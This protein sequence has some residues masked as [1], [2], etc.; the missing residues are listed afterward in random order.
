MKIFYNQCRQKATNAEYPFHRVIMNEN[1]FRDAV[2]YDHVCVQYKDNRRR[3]ENYVQADCSMFDVDNIHSDNAN[4]WLTPEDIKKSFPGVQ[5]YI[6]FSRNHMKEKDGKRPRPKFHVYFPHDTICDSGEY[7]QLKERVCRYFCGFDKNA[8]D[9]ARFFY[10]VENPQVMYV[11]GEIRLLNFMETA[12][13]VSI[14]CSQ[15]GTS[16][17]EADIIPQGERNNTLHKYALKVLTRWGDTEAARQAYLQKSKTCIPL[18]EQQEID[19]IWRGAQKYYCENI[20]I[21]PDYIPPE[22]FNFPTAKKL[23]PSDFTDVGE[24]RVLANVFGNITG[25]SAA[26]KFLY[27]TGTVWSEDEIKVHGLAQELT[28]WQLQTLTG[29]KSADGEKEKAYYKFILRCRDS[30]HISGIMREVQPMVEIDVSL[31]DADGMKLNTPGGLVDLR[32]GETSPH[33]PLDYCTKI[34]AAEPNNEGAELFQT[35]LETITCGDTDLQEYLQI[36]A[37]MFLVGK[38]FRENLIIAYGSGRNGKSTFFN[39]I[40]L[41]LGS[42]AGMV[43]A[44]ILT[45]RSRKNKSP[46]FAELRGKRFIIAA[47]LEEGMRL[48]TSVVKKLCST[49]PIYA[50]KKYKDPFQF[51]PS[52]TIVLYTNHLPAVGTIDKGTWRRLVV[53]PFL[54]EIEEQ[55]DIKNYAEFLYNQ[56][57]GAILSWMI[58]GAKKFIQSNC[59]VTEPEVVRQAIEQ[60]RAENDWLNNFIIDRCETGGGLSVKSGELYKAY[61][62]YC[63]DT[64]ERYVRPASDFKKALV[65]AGYQWNRNSKGA[66][67]KGLQLA[68]EDMPMVDSVYSLPEYNFSREQEMTEDDTEDINF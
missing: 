16:K 39:A 52:H 18:L 17:H 5:H 41:V 34:T 56:A 14:P 30:R 35:F 22:Q 51:I 26:T 9:V 6:V 61:Q 23:K 20:Q 55:N 8:K 66:Y 53:I 19:E 67:Y 57:G 31:L 11:D 25:Y 43:S 3:K 21:K 29:K 24:A 63:E 60:Y 50:E 47:E 68:D 13:A 42:Y 36:I 27:Y 45:S 64:G 48:D 33:N 32:T 12:S 46:E 59:K 37:G 54:A 10:G 62:K 58:E 2:H 4:E 28:E 44:E 7:E 49:D 1:D 15:N 38:V 40:S 65:E